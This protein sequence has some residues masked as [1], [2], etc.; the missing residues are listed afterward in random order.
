M[1]DDAAITLRRHGNP[2]GTRLVLCHGNGLSIDLYY[3]FWSMLTDK[4]DIVVYDLRSHGWNAVSPLA[5]HTVP[6]FTE[7]HERIL[8]AIDRR[9]GS[10]PQVGRVPLGLVIRAAAVTH[11]GQPILGPRP[12]RSTA[13]QT[14]GDEQRVRRGPRTN[15]QDRGAAHTGVR[16]KGGLHRPDGLPSDLQECRAR[17]H[18][19]AGRNNPARGP[20]TAPASNCDARGSTR[21]QII[22]HARI[23]AVAGRLRGSRVS[24]QGDRG[25][26]DGCRTRTCRRST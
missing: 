10:K 1:D 2:D 9:Y 26:S 19:P 21:P 12:V 5:N 17:C 22:A 23:F 16:D 24:H 8:D 6:T 15:S 7:D 14:G 11:A 13:A 4:F 18:R 3:P 20:R 25:R